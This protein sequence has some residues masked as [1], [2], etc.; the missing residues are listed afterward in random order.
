MDIIATGSTTN[1]TTT[2]FTENTRPTS[3]ITTI[4]IMIVGTARTIVIIIV[5][6]LPCKQAVKNGFYNRRRSM[7]LRRYFLLK[8]K[9]TNI[10]QRN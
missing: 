3:A 10:A 2:G 9:E 1:T 6:L 4:S 7:I 5:N 8:V